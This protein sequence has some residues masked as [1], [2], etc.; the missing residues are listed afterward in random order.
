MVLKSL[1]LK[2]VFTRYVCGFPSTI[3]TQT[4]QKCAGILV[5]GKH[6]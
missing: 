4:R 5:Y 1:F 3:F 2:P 6:F